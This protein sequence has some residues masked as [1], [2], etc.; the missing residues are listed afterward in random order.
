MIAEKKLTCFPISLKSQWAK[1]LVRL[2]LADEL[3]ELQSRYSSLFGS[4]PLPML[5]AGPV[6]HDHLPTDPVYED[7]DTK[8]A[9][10]GS[11]PLDSVV[12]PPRKVCIISAGVAGLYIAMILDDLRIPNLTYDILESS[13]RVG[14]RVLT[15]KFSDAPHDYYDIG[16]MRYPQIPIMDRTFDLFKRTN[17]PLIPYYLDGEACPKLF[18]D[19]LYVE[20][21]KDP[22]HVGVRNGGS[23]PDHVVDNVTDCLDKAFGPFKKA[24]A[25]D[26]KSGWQALMTVDDFSTR[27]YLKR[28]GPRGTEPKYDFFSIQWMETQD[29]S[30]NLF[31]QAFS[32]S[33]M[34]SFDFDYPQEEDVKWSC[35]EGGTHLLTKAMEKSLKTRV[36]TGKRVE[37]IS[38]DRSL[39][40]DGNM[41]VKCADEGMREGYSTVFNTAPLGCVGRMDLT[42]LDLHPSQKDAIRSLH[43]DD[44]VKVA[45]KFSQPWWIT[46]CG[47]KSG[48]VSSTDLPLRTCVYPSYNLHDGAHKPAVLLASYTWS[49]DATR[50]GSLLNR[51]GY[52]PSE[53]E[54]VE[55]ILRNLAKLHESTITYDEIR[56]AYTGVYNA[57]SWSHNP[58][59][60]GA[61]ALFGPG[62]FSNL[63][64]YL[65]RPTA[66]SKFHFVGE[67]ASVHHAWIVGALD[68]AYSAVYKF[69]YRFK[70]YHHIAIL[71]RRWGDVEELETGKHGTVHLQV[72][73]G[74]LQEKYKIQV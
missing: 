22:Y 16:A 48:G 23:V 69:L 12:I 18:N 28:G 55:L 73:L 51:P 43:Y 1:H 65:S 57:Y 14:G 47:I 33:V 68:S 41:R 63:Y 66:D 32:E 31:D 21:E 19:R 61:F 34:D 67:A 30:T 54:L 27:E 45:L 13:S 6:T 20:G 35:I 59:S 56:K 52:P 36:S 62:Q 72:A 74:A 64:P 11:S 7:D 44:S 46:K 5:G 2:K 3:N 38:I 10:D 49:Q 50:M 15:H 9:L 29:T 71:Q 53:E 24:L 70:L 26:F 39:H 4:S 40:Q 37:A 8:D 17:V 60:A 58:N 42:K 25:H